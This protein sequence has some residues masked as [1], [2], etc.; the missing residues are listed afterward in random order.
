MPNI[1]A[2]ARF[3]TGL[4]KVP[5]IGII[6]EPYVLRVEDAFSFNSNQGAEEVNCGE[7]R[8]SSR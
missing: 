5:P 2:R 8:E 6:D 3:E 7:I 1:I 4:G